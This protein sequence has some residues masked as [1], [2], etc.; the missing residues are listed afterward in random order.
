MG[1]AATLAA[2][3]AS[4]AG[5]F[6][7]K[8]SAPAKGDDWGA[9]LLVKPYG[10]H[11]PSDADVS[12]TAEGV[13]GGKRQT[14]KLDLTLRPAGDY[15]IRRQWP[16]QGTWVVAITGKYMGATRSALVTL[17]TG[18]KAPGTKKDLQIRLFERALTA[19]EVT[20]AIDSAGRI[21]SR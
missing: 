13:V 10:C 11:K 4:L 8:V 2:V 3:T 19:E 1:V 15:A 12:A 14:I 7:L 16:D 5:G 20:A 18:K 21:A 9:V 6:Y 17:A